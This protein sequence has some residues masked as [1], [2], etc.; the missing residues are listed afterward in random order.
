MLL[1]RP[2]AV[3]W[4]SLACGVP[5]PY[6]Q[7]GTRC[8]GLGLCGPVSPSQGGHSSAIPRSLSVHMVLLHAQLNA[9]AS[10]P[11]F[12]GTPVMSNLYPNKQDSS[13]P[14]KLTAF[15]GE[16]VCWNVVSLLYFLS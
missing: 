14:L 13:S 4:H 1:E 15:R 10:L 2:E 16:A 12:S 7:V 11:G 8:Q 5:A 3:G 9:W 6:A